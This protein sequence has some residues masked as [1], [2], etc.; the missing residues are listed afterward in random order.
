MP[1]HLS[2]GILAIAMLA[3][4]SLSRSRGAAL[5]EPTDAAAVDLEARRDLAHGEPIIPDLAELRDL[6]DTADLASDDGVCV[7]LFVVCVNP[8]G[9]GRHCCAPLVCYAASCIATD[10]GVWCE[11]QCLRL[12]GAACAD[13]SECIS[14]VCAAGVCR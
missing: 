13:G 4:C 8:L 14:G 1:D 10:G 7:Q 5:D 12:G 2:F 3:G 9:K 11:E 6:G